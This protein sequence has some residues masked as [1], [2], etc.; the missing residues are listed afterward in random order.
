MQ[1]QL[2]CRN[3]CDKGNVVCV[4]WLLLVVG[5]VDITTKGC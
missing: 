5:F 1:R 2:R 4:L 3:V